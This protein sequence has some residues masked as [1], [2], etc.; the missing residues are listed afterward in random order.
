MI[1]R[2]GSAAAPG[3]TNRIRR[4]AVLTYPVR[5]R[6]AQVPTVH[7]VTVAAAG[8]TVTVASAPSLRLVRVAALSDSECR[9]EHS[10]K[11]PRHNESTTKMMVQSLLGPVLHGEPKTRVTRRVGVRQM[12][13]AV[14]H[15]PGIRL[16]RRAK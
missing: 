12:P 16:R 15:R 4:A 3:P 1:V 8:V 2:L 11:I 6:V 14:C 13:L 5:L 7:A 9:V 10:I